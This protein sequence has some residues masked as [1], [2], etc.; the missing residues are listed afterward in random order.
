MCS[1]KSVSWPARDNAGCEPHQPLA[2]RK[3]TAGKGKDKTE[4]LHG[5]GLEVRGEKL[6]AD[7][8][9]RRGS[10]EATILRRL[11]LFLLHSAGVTEPLSGDSSFLYPA[12]CLS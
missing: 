2:K 6:H 7:M 3:H 11:P 4:A 12:G 9:I 10:I 1:W 8:E 5:L